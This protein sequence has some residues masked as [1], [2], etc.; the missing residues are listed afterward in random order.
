M[1]QI[2]PYLKKGNCT[3][4]PTSR[5]PNDR[6]TQQKSW[7]FWSL[8]IPGKMTGIPNNGIPN[9]GNAQRLECPTVTLRNTQQWEC[10]TA[11]IPNDRIPNDGIPNKGISSYYIRYNM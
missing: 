1:Q 8:G 11:G 9:G 4:Y 6:N 10:P 5:I 3:E 2:N 7:L